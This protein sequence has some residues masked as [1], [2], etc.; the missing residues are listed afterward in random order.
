[1]SPLVRSTERG[2]SDL[3]M[4][5]DVADLGV[6]C[7]PAASRPVAWGAAF[8]PQGQ[9]GPPRAAGGASL[10]SAGA[11]RWPEP[12]AERQQLHT[13]VP[14]R[15]DRPATVRR[16]TNPGEEIKN[17]HLKQ[18]RIQTRSSFPFFIMSQ[19]PVE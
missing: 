14:V 12:S 6:G 4:W 15:S 13:A 3:C 10:K 19:S 17:N 2:Q 9:P 7:V 5:S 11:S 16:N 8:K 18:G 1:M